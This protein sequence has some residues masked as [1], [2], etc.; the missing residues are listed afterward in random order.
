MNLLLYTVAVWLNLRG[1]LAEDWSDTAALNPNGNASES[2]AAAGANQ[3]FYTIEYYRRFFD[4][5]TPQ[6]RYL[7]LSRPR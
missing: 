3:P 7:V 5:D 2:T 6:V 1:F 4:V